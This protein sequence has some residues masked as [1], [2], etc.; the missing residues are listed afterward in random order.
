MGCR[1][2]DVVQGG[3]AVLPGRF[4]G[5][6]V[7]AAARIRTASRAQIG[8]ALV[9]DDKLLP[10]ASEARLADMRGVL[11]ALASALGFS[12]LGIW[13]K[14]ATQYE[15]A[16]YTVLPWRFGLV[17]ALLLCISRQ[18]LSLRD[19]SVM[20]GTGL[21]YVASTG[22]YFAALARIS[23]GTSSL[24]L[25][26]APSF[27][28]F[29][30]RMLGRRPTRFQ[31]IAVVLTL[32][33]LA[34]VIGLPG[35]QDSDILGLGLAVATGALY[36]AYL[37]ASERLLAPYPPIA[38]TGHMTLAAALC[39]A[40]AGAVTGTLGVPTGAAQWSITLGMI[41]FPTLIAIPT[42]YASIRVIGAARASIVAT[43]E[44]MWTVL[45]AALVLGEPLGPGV[46]VGGLLILSGALLSQ[47]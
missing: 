22:C 20:F 35:A 18:R 43:T 34:F 29:Y 21:L 12:S 11:L 25:Y 39:F 38:A 36:G 31:L 30:G 2:L 6:A 14:L 28:V 9:A 41:I 10:A 44:P 47:R 46:I 5:G 23:A 27:V 19:R 24:L 8:F 26:L 45:L 42:L 33:G 15:L 1:P 37:I 32:I 7:E 16:T 17:A 4:A 3:F 40:I 13:G